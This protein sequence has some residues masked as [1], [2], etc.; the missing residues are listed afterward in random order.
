MIITSEAMMPLDTMLH[1]HFL[2]K[3]KGFFFQIIFPELL[4]FSK[5]GY[6]QLATPM[7]QTEYLATEISSIR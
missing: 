1:G 2:S 5:H 4:V 3:C 6:K 7:Q